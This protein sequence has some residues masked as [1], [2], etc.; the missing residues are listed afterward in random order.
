[1][2]SSKSNMPK[3]I[4]YLIL[5]AG[6]CGLGAAYRLK[7]LGI[8]DFLILEKSERVGGLA[9]SYVDDNGFT[10]DIG[11]HVQFSHYDYFDEA[12][13]KALGKDGWLHHEREAW[14]WIK[15]RFVPYPFQNNIHRLPEEDCSKCFEGMVNR[16]KP[17]IKINNFEDWLRSSFGEGLCKLFMF[18]Y[19][20]KVW[21]HEPKELNYSWVG[22]RVA[23]IDLNR[24]EE[25][26]K[27]K[28][29]DVSW[30]P[31]NTFQFPLK[32]GTGAIWNSVGE[33]V[34]LKNIK[35]NSPALEINWKNKT[36][37]TEDDLFEYEHVLSTLPLTALTKVMKEPELEELSSKLKSSGTHVIGIGLEGELPK[38]LEGKC[39]MYFPESDSPFYRV[40]VFSNYSPNNVPDSKTQ[41]SLMA[42]VSESEQKPVNHQTIIEDTIQG[43]K[44][45]GLITD[46]KIISTWSFKAALGYPTPSL[47]RDTILN[48]LIP[49]LD[50]KGISSRGRFGAWKYEISNQDHTFMQ[51]VEWVNKLE[52]GI[53]EETFRLS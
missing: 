9:T 11:G 15:Q 44:N 48:E 36:V 47:E 27:T 18:P 46:E 7:D 8:E 1:M 24:I 5:G 39:W 40:T 33:I 2:M 49:S 16:N 25:N 34:G 31:N 30:G 42:E 3:K 20:F 35:T 22:E 12:M 41:F 37:R 53:D 10:W 50:E 43:M 6:P 51:G 14:V 21:A 32:G 23:Q 19:N 38:Q 26:I 17:E 4:K 45:C 29:D 13:L 28:K 52:K